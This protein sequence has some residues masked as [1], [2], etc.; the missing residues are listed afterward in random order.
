[1]ATY[2]RNRLLQAIPTVFLV[3]VVIFLMLHLTPSDPAEI[4]M[5]EARSTPEM[6]DRIRVDMGL[7][8]PLHVQYLRWLLGDMP[9]ELGDITIWEGR[10]VPIYDNEGKPV[11]TQF[12]EYYGIL[13]G[14]FGRSLTYRLPVLD[15]ILDRVPYT[16]ELAVTAF[17]LS[18]LVGMTLGIIAALRHGTIIDTVSMTVALIGISVPVYWSALMLILLFSVNLKWFPPIGQG[19]LDRLVLPAVALSFVSS[20]TLARMVRSSMLEVLTQDYVVTARA[21][22]LRERVVILRHT[23]QNALIP[24][25]TVLGL[26]IGRLLSGAVL[27][28]TVFS[29]LGL[30]K[31]FAAA[32]LNKDFT[33]VQGTALII[34]LVYVLINIGTDLVYAYVDPRIK[35]E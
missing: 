33:L 23:L 26:M 29:R 15:M 9:I 34:A 22:G 19:S 3:T 24:V 2:L 28:E 11:D 31:M 10:E 25:I 32:V 13:R 27:T 1:M 5:G 6:L 14:D 4:F 20:G 21:K 35:Y 17:L 18:T 8:Q 12:K 16:V 7:N 30:G